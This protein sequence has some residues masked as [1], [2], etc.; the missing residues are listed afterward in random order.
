MQ[1]THGPARHVLCMVAPRDGFSVSVYELRALGLPLSTCSN[2]IDGI[3][4]TMARSSSVILVRSQLQSVIIALMAVAVAARELVVPV[5]P[6]PLRLWLG[7]L[8]SHFGPIWAKVR[9]RVW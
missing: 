8:W 7:T 2:L 9:A 3:N 5:R 6:E 1:E 4:K